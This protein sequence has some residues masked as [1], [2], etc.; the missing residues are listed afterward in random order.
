MND[1]VVVGGG[2]AGWMTASALVKFFPNR[3]ITVIES[4]DDPIIG[5]GESTFDKI[6]YFLSMLEIDR[7]DFFAF[8]DASIKLAVEFSEFYEKDN[9]NDFIY[10]FGY[11]NVENN[12]DGLQDWQVKKTIYKDTPITEFA[13]WHFPQASL[14]K[15]NRFS[16]NLDNDLPYFHPERDTALHFDAVKFGQWLKNNYSIPR[17]VK[18][19]NLKVIDIPVNEDGIEK[20]VLSDGTE[21]FADLF[22]DCTGFSSLLIEQT[23]KEN[24]IS[25]EDILPNNHAWAVQMPY[26]NKP[27]E[28]NNKTR[29]VALDNGWVWNIGLY[30]RLGV[31]Y[32]YSDKFITDEEA[33]EEFKN[34]LK[35]KMKVPRSEEEINQFTFRNLKFRVGIHERTWVKNVVAIGLSA[36]FIEPLESNGLYTV[37]EFI[38]ELI[39]VLLKEKHNQWDIDVYN[40]ATKTK[41]DGFVDFIKIHYCLSKRKDSE[42]WRYVTSMSND[43]DF[44]NQ[45]NVLRFN[46]ERLKSETGKLPLEGGLAWISVGMNFLIIDDVAMK[47]NEYRSGT[48]HKILFEPYFRSMDNRKK[49]W[50]KKA[51]KCPTLYEYLKYKYYG[52]KP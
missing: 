32:V 19:I 6:N 42:Y 1:I 20:L 41:F 25:Y 7:K 3:K 11:P 30:S 18:Y 9:H 27:I 17:G 2:S 43:I 37:H 49:L 46:L 21:I 29:C 22:V 36:G 34:Y 5:V 12:L 35:F 33:L 44:L 16:E 38:Y 28:L 4:P 23:L 31:G 51:L 39:K 52:G 40:K 14:V 48:S 13:E 26:I 8:T 45:R 10:P 47:I 15:H 50:E 24:F